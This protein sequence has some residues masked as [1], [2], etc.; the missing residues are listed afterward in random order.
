[1]IRGLRGFE[2]RCSL[3]TWI[4][5][6]LV[7][8]ARSMAVRESRLA[9]PATRPEPEVQS[10]EGQEWQ[11]GSGRVGLWTERPVPWGLSDP[12]ALFQTREA[13]E[14]VQ[15]AVAHLPDRQRQALLLRDFEDLEPKDVCNILE[16]S[17]TNLRVLL[18]R[19]RAR[20][21]H[22]MDQYVRD[23]ARSTIRSSDRVTRETSPSNRVMHARG[24]RS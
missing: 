8:R 20:V 2:G 9:G 5:S 22:A 14:V 23:G 3:R 12:A 16:V 4:F 15:D 11:Y 1:V 6:I 18:H 10:P 17:E 24:K 13:L 19:G 7:R 21:R